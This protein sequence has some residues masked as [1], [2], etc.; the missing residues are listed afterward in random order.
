MI[1]NLYQN[2]EVY[3]W[4]K[5]RY[6]II[7]VQIFGYM[8]QGHQMK[9]NWCIFILVFSIIVFDVIHLCGGNGW[10]QQRIINSRAHHILFLFSSHSYSSWYF[11]GKVRMHF[12][13]EVFNAIGKA[14]LQ[15]TNTIIPPYL[16]SSCFVTIIFVCYYEWIR[17]RRKTV[18]T[19]SNK[20]NLV[21]SQNF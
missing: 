15:T 10:E 16:I 18:K 3:R 13:W 8:Y 7:K 4:H 2:I 17:N 9:L 12:T 19:F 11:P 6:K 20:K 14:L 1:S 21:W 5:D